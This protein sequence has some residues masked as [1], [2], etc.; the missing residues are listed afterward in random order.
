MRALHL[1]M[2]AEGVARVHGLADGFLSMSDMNLEMPFWESWL[3]TG[4]SELKRRA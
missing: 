2:R 1:L 4:L 3:G